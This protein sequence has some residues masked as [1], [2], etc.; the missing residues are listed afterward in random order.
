MEEIPSFEKIWK[1]VICDFFKH[2]NGLNFPHEPINSGNPD[3]FFE[4]FILASP[5]SDYASSN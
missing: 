1:D 2:K 3:H 5:F 4:I